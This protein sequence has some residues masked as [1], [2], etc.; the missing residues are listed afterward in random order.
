M[1]KLAV[2]LIVLLCLSSTAYNSDEACYP[3]KSKSYARDYQVPSAFPTIQSA[4]D[5]VMTT[6][7][8]DATIVVEEGE[9]RESITA[10]GLKNLKLIGRKAKILPPVDFYF[11]DPPTDDSYPASSLKLVD[12]ENFMV[13]GF[14]FIGNDFADNTQESYPMGSSILSLNSSGII[15]K[16][17]IFNYF[18]GISFRVSNLAWMTGEISD[19]YI[20]NCLWSG[21]FATG[22]HHLKIQKNKIVFTIPAALSIAVGIWTDDGGIGTISSNHITSYRA[23]DGHR[24][25][26]TESELDTWQIN[27]GIMQKLDYKVQDNIF[28]P[29]AAISRFNKL[30]GATDLPYGFPRSNLRI[31]N[32]FI[33]ANLNKQ[34]Q[35]P[36]GMV[37][38]H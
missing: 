34:L 33:N 9:Y 13:E 15:S 37:L 2:T 5:A 30:P 28:E 32:Y 3:R 25:Q 27:L 11:P 26:H 14:T 19:N 4:L 16:N 22:S 29:S 8:E 1:K 10:I 35:D 24:P 6:G 17:I 21:I 18:D 23:V 20:H 36:K 31:G 7:A 38:V 12:C